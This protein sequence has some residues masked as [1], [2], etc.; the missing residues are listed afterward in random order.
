MCMGVPCQQSHPS[1]M[2]TSAMFARACIDSDPLQAVR[3]HRN[4]VVDW[5]VAS[6]HR[7]ET[8]PQ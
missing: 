2:G 7:N 6:G 5:L 8:A 1:A 3:G 4:Y